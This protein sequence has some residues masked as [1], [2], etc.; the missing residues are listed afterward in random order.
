MKE[1]TEV[2]LTAILSI[3]IAYT[4]TEVVFNGSIILASI[5]LGCIIS[6]AANVLAKEIVKIVCFLWKKHRK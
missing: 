4:W 3:V 1:V 2:F 5:F 6:V